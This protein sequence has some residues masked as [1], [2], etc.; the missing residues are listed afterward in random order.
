MVD[1][2]IYEYNSSTTVHL[3]DT[4]GFDDTT[5]TNSEVLKEIAAWL[6]LTYSNNIKLDGIVYLHRIIDP[7]M[8]GSAKTSLKM[9][10]NLCEL[11]A[12][13]HVVLATTFWEQVGPEDGPKREQQ[14]INTLEFWGQM[15]KMRCRV[16]RHTNDRASALRILD[17][18]VKKQSNKSKMMLKLQTDMMNKGILLKD[19][20]V[21]RNAAGEKA[22]ANAREASEKEFARMRADTKKAIEEHDQERAKV[23]KQNQKNLK[24]K[25]AFLDQEFENE[26]T[27]LQRDFEAKVAGLEKENKALRARV[28]QTSLPPSSKPPEKKLR[29]DV[30]QPASSLKQKNRILSSIIEKSRDLLNAARSGK[31]SD[32]MNALQKGVY[33]NIQDSK[34]LTPLALAIKGGSRSIV[35]TLLRHHADSNKADNLENMPLHHATMHDHTAI[36]RDLLLLSDNIDINQADKVG[37]NVLHFAI[38]KANVVIAQTLLNSGARIDQT[39]MFDFTSLLYAICLRHETLAILLL[40]HGA[41]VNKRGSMPKKRPSLGQHQLHDFLLKHKLGASLRGFSDLTSALAGPLFAA[42]S[43]YDEKITRRL[44]DTE[45]NT[46]SNI[47]VNGD[48]VLHRAI[49][50]KQTTLMR[51]L[52]AHKANVDAANKDGYTPLHLALKSGQNDIIQLL[53]SRN[54]NV[55]TVATNEES[56][57]HTAMKIGDVAIAQTLLTRGA[58][59]RSGNQKLL[60]HIAARSEHAA[61]IRFLL[62][63]GA[64]VNE[65]LP[66]RRGDEGTYFRKRQGAT[67]LFLTTFHEHLEAAKLLVNGETDLQQ[68]AWPKD[69]KLHKSDHCLFASMSIWQCNVVHV[70]ATHGHQQLA[71]F[72]IQKGEKLNA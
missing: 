44:L 31:L 65:Q 53:I 4:P 26:R 41:D 18:F 15:C 25:M 8:Q 37:V 63:H 56:P 3:I 71:K 67:S 62:M 61:L 42:V 55:N 32:V 51:T 58:K 5:K 13:K 20:Q 19:T 40:R 72:L 69:C 2:F 39:D 29:I 50:Q 1:E 24:K 12:I 70:A 68:G 49:R 52:L 9:L 30:S 23:V 34:S 33:I 35:E 45:A 66:L 21:G 6:T 16:M 47:D 10:K 28:F 57:L 54:P 59:I 46:E 64:F 14:L 17:V 22:L 60:L 27:K 7:R 11:D 43:M 36:V 48:R 38:L